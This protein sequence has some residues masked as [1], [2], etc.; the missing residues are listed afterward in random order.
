MMAGQVIETWARHQNTDARALIMKQVVCS[1]TQQAVGKRCGVKHADKHTIAQRI[2][3]APAGPV[4]AHNTSLFAAS[5]KQTPTTVLCE[6][7]REVPGKV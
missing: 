7:S 1:S 6:D 4:H 5:G 2:E 3:V